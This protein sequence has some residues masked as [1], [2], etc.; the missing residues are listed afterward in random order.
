MR[1]LPLLVS[2]FVLAL[3]ACGLNGT[4]RNQDEQ[5]ADSAT[6]NVAQ[7]SPADP[8]L[9]H[10]PTGNAPLDPVLADDKQIGRAHV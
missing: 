9:S 10:D 5:P 1:A 8:L 6:P 3:A 2:P 4:D 7:A